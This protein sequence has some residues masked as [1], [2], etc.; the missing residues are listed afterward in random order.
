MTR[1][2]SDRLAASHIGAKLS[3]QPSADLQSAGGMTI[4]ECRLVLTGSKGTYPLSIRVFTHLGTDGSQAIEARNMGIAREP[5]WKQ[6]GARLEESRVGKAICILTGRPSVASHAICSRK[7]SRHEP[8]RYTIS[9]L[10]LG[11]G[12]RENAS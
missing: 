2:E 11:T 5:Q 3:T 8:Q 1:R 10:G 6:P 9:D 7:R 12:D 4:D